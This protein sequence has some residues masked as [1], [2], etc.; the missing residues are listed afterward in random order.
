MTAETVLKKYF[1]YDNFR[2]H[3]KIV[4]DSIMNGEDCLVIM[5]TGG[6][7]SLCYQIPA[8]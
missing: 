6:G 1:G 7:K 4:I 2:L 3:Q 8:L 5:P